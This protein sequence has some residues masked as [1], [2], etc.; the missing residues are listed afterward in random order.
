MKR[1]TFTTTAAAAG[2]LSQSSP[3]LAAA[4]KSGRKYRTA[5]LGS[6]WWGMNV[7]R[8][9]M[10][11][12]TVQVVALNDVFDDALETSAEEVTDLSGDKPRIYKDYRELLE[13]EKPEIVI[14]ATPDHWHALQ[15][16][17]AVEAGAHVFVEKPTGHTILE[18]QAMV[19]AARKAGT[20]IQVGL[21]RRI[22]T[23]HVSGMKFLKSGKVGKVGMVRM[24]VSGRGGQEKPR[25]NSEPPKG[26]DWDMYCGPAPL[27]PFNS[28]IHPGGF[29]NFLDFANGTLG[30]WGVHWL[31]QVLW[32]TEEKY[33]RRVFSTGGRPVRGEPVFNEKEQTTDA[34]DT[35]I[36]VYE[37]ESFTATWEHRRYADNP[38]EKHKIGCYFYG[39]N[40]I[41]HMG[42]RD[43]WTFYPAN[44]KEKVIHED[45][46]LQEPDG[47]NLKLLWQDF[48]DAIE[49][50]KAPVCGIESSH[51]SSVLPLLGMISLKV[52]RSLEWDGAREQIVGDADANKLL[53]RDYRGPWVYPTT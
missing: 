38:S 24:F 48:I 45:S 23:H 39:E 46:Q 20:T 25:P 52:G 31:D 42:W 41:F 50:R 33:P 21:H 17:A 2:L 6:G 22:G 13:K 19:H 32:W 36:A 14:I 29:R 27:R 11:S 40:G 10:E 51:R 5:L 34:P 4:K 37:F 53:K 8:E 15:T 18:S 43:G 7:L 30:D 47:H 3:L 49:G 16:I 35:Q 26:M 12:G 44:P 28:R 9:A 1:R